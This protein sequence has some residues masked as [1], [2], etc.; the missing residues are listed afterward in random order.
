MD[1]TVYIADA[2]ERAHEI[3]TAVLDGRLDDV[4]PSF[5]A[6]LLD[7]LTD[8]VWSDGLATIAGL[9]GAFEGFGDGE[10]FVRRIGDHT[11]VDIPLRYE[12]GDMK[13]RVAFD[14]EPFP[15]AGADIALRAWYPGMRQR[16]PD[17]ERSRIIAT[18]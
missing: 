8:E 7:A 5:N 18:V 10:P 17:F 9:V 14:T 2:A 13:G 1:K 3:I 11:V 16:T 4:R 12:A 6:Q 15:E